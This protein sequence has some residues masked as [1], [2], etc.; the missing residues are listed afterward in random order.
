MTPVHPG[1]ILKREL[2]ARGLSA[3]RLALALRVPSGRIT[4]I[5]NGKR[6]VTPE[7][8]LRFAR[9]FGT[10]AEFWVN[11]QARYDLSMAAKKLGARIAAE[12]P[13]AAN[14]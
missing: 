4:D 5:L 13:R 3:N 6:G 10:S 14:A 2:I 7:T 1:R 8:A 9:F 12:V 11:L